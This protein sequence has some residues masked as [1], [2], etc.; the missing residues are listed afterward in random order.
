MEQTTRAEIVLLADIMQRNDILP[1]TIGRITEKDFYHKPHS[2][3]FK[4]MK[5]L[6]NQSKPIDPPIL[7]EHLGVENLKLVGG[8]S[9]LSKIPSTTESP[10]HYKNHLE[11]VKN[12]SARRQLKD[13]FYKGIREI[14]QGKDPKEILAT[15][16][17]EAV[18]TTYSGIGETK[19]IDEI[20]EIDLLEFENEYYNGDQ[21]AGVTTGYQTLDQVTGGLVKGDYL[22]IAGR[23]SMGKTAFLLNIL[24]QVPTTEKALFFSMEMNAKRL[25][26]RILASEAGLNSR[27]VNRAQVTETQ[28]TNQ[29]VNKY[30]EIGSRKNLFINDSRGLTVEQ[31]RAEAKKVKAQNPDLSVIC[32]DHLGK[33]RSNNKSSKYEKV[34]EISGALAD[35]AGELEVCL[36]V[37][38]QLNRASVATESKIPDLSHLRD[39]G[40]IEEDA[41]QVLLLHRED[42]YL[43]TPPEIS[44]LIV[45]VAKNRDGER[46]AIKFDYDLRTQKIKE[47]K[48]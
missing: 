16:Q 11:I 46:K 15:L 1:E 28:F 36:I 25:F 5:E 23:P 48:S 32:I 8:I 39:S 19:R 24:R 37:L 30:G 4:A 13:S 27:A 20:A 26:R 33:I 9:Y 12:N 2:I 10:E 6:Y 41:D 45:I 35:L 7:A 44:E 31:I 14:E 18:K 29:I 21:L 3:I 43:Q 47:K 17:G 34:G 40:N 42:Y 22:I 38:S